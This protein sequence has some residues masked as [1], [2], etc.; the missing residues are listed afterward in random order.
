MKNLFDRDASTEI[1]S[2]LETLQPGAKP[3]W[4]KMSVSQMMAHCIVPIKVSLGEAKIKRNF[5]GLLFG[6]MGKKMVL[7]DEPFKKG[8]PTDPSFIIKDEPDFNSK[9][10]E[11]KTSI[12]KLL[13]TDKNA[14]ASRSHPFF[15]KMTVDE[16]GVL[17]YKHLDHHLRQFGV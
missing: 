2:R 17:G 4:G 16:W 8:L 15:G 5:M 9:K 12:D 10:Q 6:K 7:K 3:L 14:M 11:L 13:T 1:L